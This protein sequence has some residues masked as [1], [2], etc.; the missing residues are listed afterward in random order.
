MSK[1]K[2]GGVEQTRMG[3][4][5]EQTK[6]GEGVEQTRMGMGDEQTKR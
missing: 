1:L 5:D 4:G 6:R 2:E 3:R